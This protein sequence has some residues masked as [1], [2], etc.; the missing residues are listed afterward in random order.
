MGGE[1]ERVATWLRRIDELVADLDRIADPVARERSRELLQTVLDLHGLA[2]A[3]LTAL[4]AR[5]P[6]GSELLARFGEDPVARPVLLLYGLH[7]EDLET[8]VRKAAARLEPALTRHGANADIVVRPARG[9]LVRIAAPPE[10]LA[11][12]ED[13]R[14]EIEAALLEAAPEL[15]SIDVEVLEPRRPSAAAAE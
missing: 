2:L 1:G 13:L 7:P 15:E 14:G 10:A 6:G 4:V 3:R 9:V 5:T 8:R 11:A 12:L